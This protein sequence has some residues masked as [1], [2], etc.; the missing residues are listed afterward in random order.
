LRRK[1]EEVLK[2]SSMVD[3]IFEFYGAVKVVFIEEVKRRNER[4]Y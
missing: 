1:R 3:T 4:T 2:A